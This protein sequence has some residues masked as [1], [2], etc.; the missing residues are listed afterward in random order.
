M[1]GWDMLS[2]TLHTVHDGATACILPSA[3]VCC[4]LSVTEVGGFPMV[5]ALIFSLTNLSSL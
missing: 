4:L 1:S 2:V 5:S 3:V